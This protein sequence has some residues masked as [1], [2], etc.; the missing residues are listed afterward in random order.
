MPIL[1]ENLKKAHFISTVRNPK[2]TFVSWYALSQA[3]S[4]V[5]GRWKLPPFTSVTAH[6]GFWES[7]NN[8]EMKFYV[9]EKNSTKCKGSKTV[10][11]FKSYIKNQEETVRTLYKNMGLKV[12]KEYSAALKEDAERHE[13]YKANRGYDNPSLEDLGTCAEV[14]EDK[15]EEYIDTF[16]I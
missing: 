7:F 5:M 14:V 6:M 1:E 15:L 11:T 8:A 13:N 2:D 4:L 16:K 12:S 9:T 3:A 10:V